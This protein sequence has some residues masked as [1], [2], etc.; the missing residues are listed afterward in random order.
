M[1]ENEEQVLE[2]ASLQSIYCKDGEMTDCQL[3]E[4]RK[5]RIRLDLTHPLKEL[6][7]CDAIVQFALPCDYPQISVPS[8]EVSC[9]SLDA[10]VM[11]SMMKTLNQRAI[12]L[13]G[14]MMLLDLACL[15]KELV[16]K[17]LAGAVDSNSKQTGVFEERSHKSSIV[18]GCDEQ[19]LHAQTTSCDKYYQRTNDDNFV[20]TLLHLDHMRSKP[21]YIKLIKKWAGELSLVGRLL[22]CQRVILILLQGESRDVKEYIVRNRTT[23]VDVDSR[24]RSC[25]ERMLSVL[26]EVVVLPEQILANFDVAE[27]TPEQLQ[28]FFREH[29]LGKIYA[30]HVQPL[31]QGS[32][33]S[34]R[35]T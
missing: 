32:S 4:I 33:N 11:E 31:M 28:A 16:E 5:I 10:S 23:N 12:E 3:G 15:A 1:C 17:G 2:V 29:H 13:R 35:K 6:E 34:S 14:E 8:V 7:C 9:S 21:S 24:G 30:E 22:F 25:K 27:F 19:A 20:T 26:C 18:E